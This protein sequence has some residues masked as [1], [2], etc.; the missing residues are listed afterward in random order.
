MSDSNKDY[1]ILINKDIKLYR[2]YFKE[3]TRLIGINV[4]YRA[5]LKEYKNFDGHGDLDSLY[6]KEITV[7]CIFEDHPDQKSLKKMG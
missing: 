5:P 1:G 7:G 6:T 3:M 4:K 2:N